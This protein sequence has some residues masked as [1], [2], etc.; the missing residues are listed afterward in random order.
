V[1]GVCACVCVC[2][3]GVGLDKWRV[4]PWYLLDFNFSLV[5]FAASEWTGKHYKSFKFLVHFLCKFCPPH[6]VLCWY[7]TLAFK[8][9]SLKVMLVIACIAFTITTLL[10]CKLLQE[11]STP[12]YKFWTCEVCTP[13]PILTADTFLDLLVCLHNCLRRYWGR[14]HALQELSHNSW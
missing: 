7:L 9:L 6:R 4:R 11:E 8:V 13:Y 14:Q 1:L 2:G 12:T 3:S 5:F 10:I